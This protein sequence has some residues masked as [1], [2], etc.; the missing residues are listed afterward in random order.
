MILKMDGPNRIDNLR[1]YPAETVGRL[2]S[3]LET[4]VIATPDPHRKGF[5]DLEDGDRTFYIHVSPTGTI[6]LLAEWQRE[7]AR[8]TALPETPLAEAVACCR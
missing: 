4:G 2:R 3:L 8:V 1:H 6:L 5:Y 7:A